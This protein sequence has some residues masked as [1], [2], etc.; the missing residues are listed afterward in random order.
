[1]GRKIGLL[2]IW[3]WLCFPMAPVQG[4]EFVLPP[5]PQNNIYVQDLANVLTPDTEQSILRL[6]DQLDGK[7]GAQAVVVTVPSLADRPIEEYALELFRAWGIGQKEKNNGVLVLIAPSER[8]SRIE[9]GY[10][11]EGALPDALTGRIQDGYMLPFF[12]Q[13]NF[14]QGTWQGYQAI[15]AQVAK[16]YQVDLGI[17]ADLQPAPAPKSVQAQ[18]FPWW[19]PF[20]IIGLLLVD[21]IFLGGFISRSL[22]DLL[23]WSFIFRG[24]GRGGGGGFGGGGGGFGGGSSGG[25]GSSRNW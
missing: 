20:V 17:S 8:Q 6:G 21:F 14:D 3:C 11:L 7:T 4:A 10:G 12:R 22:L 16:E 18:G 19:M 13:E 23:L 15:C 9:V 2:I 25:G 1:M 5:A 24:G